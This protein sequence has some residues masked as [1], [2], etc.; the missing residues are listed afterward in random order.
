MVMGLR[1]RLKERGEELVERVAETSISTSQRMVEGFRGFRRV[2][3]EGE[4]TGVEAYLTGLVAAVRSD[5]REE[6]ED[7]ATRRD[8]FLRARKRRRKLGL[9][10]LGTGPMAGMA[11]RVADLYCEIATLCDVADLH[12]LDLD[13]SR[14][15]AHML[16]LWSIVADQD[17]AERTMRGEPPLAQILE[18]KLTDQVGLVKVE[19]E[20]G[21]TPRSIATA[22]WD[23]QH[24]QTG[25]A[26]KGAADGQ[27]V[28][29]VLF[30]GHRTKKVIKRAEV[31]LG[32]APEAPRRWW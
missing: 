18:T 27:P 30:T 12:G 8:V 9:V 21:W 20:E 7:E 24:I 32:V 16:V 29:S 31:Q 23:V 14:V 1:R 4:Q 3:A 10:C 5:G 19:D 22:I 25:A 13:D 15:A 2:V 11:S 17:E 26:L 28:R 6:K